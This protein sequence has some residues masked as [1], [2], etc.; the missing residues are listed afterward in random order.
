MAAPRGKPPRYPFRPLRWPRLTPAQQ[1]RRARAFLAAMATR[2]SVRQ[3][4]REPVPY[5]LIEL[6][7]RAAATAPSGANQQPWR[8]AVVGD[9]ALKSRIRAAAE[10]EERESYAHRMSAE[11][12]EALAPLGTDWHKPHMED[13][14]WL[15]VVFE[16]VTGRRQDASGRT[17]SVKHY[18]PKESVGIA[19][20]LLLAALHSAGLATLVHTPSPM[21]FLGE[22]L[23]RPPNER[24]FCV[25]PVGYPSADAQVPDIPRKPLEEVLL[26]FD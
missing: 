19:V 9:P 18:Y 11:W 7:V 8:F 13:A 14:P 2:R 17:R 21:K 24:A 23:G 1:R 6:A 15:I 5:E 26:R 20:G 3:F 10:A 25:I 4:S 12:L 16:Q 22:L